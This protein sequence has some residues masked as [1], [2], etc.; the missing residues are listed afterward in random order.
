MPKF[1]CVLVA[2]WLLLAGC[3]SSA[4]AAAPTYIVAPAPAGLPQRSVISMV[5]TRDGYLW[6]GTTKG[7]ARFDGN[8]YEIFNEWNT[9]GLQRNTIVHLFEDS[10]GALWVG[11]ENTVAIL[12]NGRVN[13]LEIPG[14]AAALRSTCEDATGAVWLYLAD[15]RLVRWHEGRVQNIWVPDLAPANFRKVFTDTTGRVWIGTDTKLYEVVSDLRA[16]PF[17]LLVKSNSVPGQTFVLPS[18]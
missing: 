2:T 16:Q 5:Q 9:P 10:R 13:T 3:A 8:R 15:G 17:E 4:W 14:G 7:L 1:G 11:A 12:E 18:R 6:L